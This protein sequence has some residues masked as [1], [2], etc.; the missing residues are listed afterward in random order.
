M[1]KLTLPPHIHPEM[2]VGLGVMG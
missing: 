2:T 1:I